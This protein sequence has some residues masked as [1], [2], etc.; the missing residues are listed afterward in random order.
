MMK[1]IKFQKVTGSLEQVEILYQL[2][3][4][5]DFGI[6]HRSMP[7]FASHRNFVI[8]HPYVLWYILFMNDHPCGAVYVQ[9][10]NSVG[11]NLVDP[12]ASI[13]EEIVEF[14]RLNLFPRKKILS[15]I[16]PYFFINVSADD[17]KMNAILN[18]LR[19]KPIQ[20]S[21]RIE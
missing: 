11:V 2:L 4:K 6:S 12:Q 3:E 8:N 5:R 13:V 18:D 10:D 17:G 19:F 21:Y 1:N 15:K 7:S 20:I 9:D 16:P 14:L